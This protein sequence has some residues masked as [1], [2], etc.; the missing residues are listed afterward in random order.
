MPNKNCINI[1]ET[2]L[3]VSWFQSNIRQLFQLDSH[4]SLY[5]YGTK[6][7]IY[8]S[9]YLRVTEDTIHISAQ[10]VSFCHLCHYTLVTNK[11]RSHSNYTELITTL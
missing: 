4:Q 10:N 1:K 7:K 8:V 9:I 2:E 6:V 11:T 5:L 3:D